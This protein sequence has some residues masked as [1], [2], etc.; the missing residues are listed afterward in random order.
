MTK[1]AR[2]GMTAGCGQGNAS[3]SV[4]VMRDPR[5]TIGFTARRRSRPC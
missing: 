2:R 3:T 5:G 1:R 4:G